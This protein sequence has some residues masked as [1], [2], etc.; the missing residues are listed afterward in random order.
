MRSQTAGDRQAQVQLAMMI[1]SAAT[2]AILALARAE[3]A[4][5]LADEAG[6]IWVSRS[7]RTDLQL[8]QLMARS[9]GRLS[10]EVNEELPAADGW[11]VRAT[12]EGEE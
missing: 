3:V 5:D 11:V 4:V 2:A 7:L 12:T 6:V 10:R 8:L 9:L 1:R